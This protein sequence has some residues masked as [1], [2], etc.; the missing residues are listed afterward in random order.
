M[1]PERADERFRSAVHAY[2]GSIFDQLGWAWT[3]APPGGDFLLAGRVRV[4]AI[5]TDDP[6]SR[7]FQ[8]AARQ[9]FKDAPAGQDV[10]LVGR[11]A[12]FDGR[13]RRMYLGRLWRN[14]PA[15]PRIFD[16]AFVVAGDGIMG[17]RQD[18]L[19]LNVLGDTFDADDDFSQRFP[20]LQ[21]RAKQIIWWRVP[22]PVAIGVLL[23]A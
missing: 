21:R 20:E 17:L 11:Q 3:Y 13:R 15:Y 4:Q 10:L 9:A 23:D 18:R 12:L 1:L 5:G 2:W 6:E 19:G 8:V 22:T 16:P 7:E 14:G